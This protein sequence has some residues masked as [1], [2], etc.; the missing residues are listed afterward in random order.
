MKKLTKNKKS[1][2]NFRLFYFI[3]ILYHGWGYFA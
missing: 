2:K 1:S 3:L